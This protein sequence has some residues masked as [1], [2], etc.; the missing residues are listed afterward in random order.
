M[1][2]Q[3]K[4]KQIIPKPNN[5]DSGIDL[6]WLTILFGVI[7]GILIVSFIISSTFATDIAKNITVTEKYP[8]EYR[9]SASK[10][11]DDDGKIYYFTNDLLWAKIK[12]GETYEVRVVTKPMDARP[13]INAA[14]IGDMWYY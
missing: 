3:G 5:E 13:Y 11:I 8:Y 12:V 2:E 10:I 9:G 1:P 14:R 7:A 6:M 4:E